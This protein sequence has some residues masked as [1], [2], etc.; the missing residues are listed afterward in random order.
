MRATPRTPCGRRERHGRA[1]RPAADRSPAR[2]RR[3]RHAAGAVLRP[4]LRAGDHPVHGADGRTSTPGRASAK[5]LLV[6]GV[7][8]WAWVGYAWLTSVVDPEEGA[9]RLVDL[10][11]DGGAAGRGAVRA[12][13]V[14]RPRGCSSRGAYA[15]RPVRTDRPVRH[16]QPRRPGAAHVGARPGGRAPRSAAA[17][18]VAPRSPTARC[19]ARCGRSRCVLDMGGPFF[20]GAEGWKLVPAPLRRAPRADRDHRARRVDRRDR[21]RRAGAA[22]TPASSPPR[23]SAIAVAAALWW[24]YF[25]VVALVA[26]RGSANADAG[27]RANEIARDSFSYL[28]FP[29]VAGIVLVALGFKKTLGA[30]RG[31]AATR[32]CRQRCSAARRSTCSPTSRSAGATFTAFSSQR[33]GGSRC[34]HRA[35]PL[36]TRVPALLTLSLLAAILATVVLYEPPIPAG[37]R[38]RDSPLPLRPESAPGWPD[39]WRHAWSSHRSRTSTLLVP[40]HRAIRDLVCRSV[41][42]SARRGAATLRS[43]PRLPRLPLPVHLSH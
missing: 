14:R 22:S 19:R 10:R 41:P 38:V 27:T 2:R 39:C 4:R 9:V 42:P 43:P 12:D 8:W 24:L 17:L 7:L 29:M 15:R 40:R 37:C 36:A 30:R 1:Q 32:R 25:D 28:H 20:F 23:C 18:L 31:R 11:R 16:R 34:M 5:G 35:L 13:R 3:A 33:R 21:R 26:A 6:L